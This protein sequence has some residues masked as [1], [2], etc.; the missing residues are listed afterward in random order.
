MEIQITVTKAKHLKEKEMFNLVDEKK[1]I[2]SQ[3]SATL[4]ELVHCSFDI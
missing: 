1:A 4:T 3:E 2:R